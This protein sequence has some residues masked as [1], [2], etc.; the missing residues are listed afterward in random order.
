MNPEP[1]KSR[2]VSVGGRLLSGVE[3]VGLVVIAIATIIAGIQ[4]ITEMV[5]RR[6]VSLGDLLLLFIYLEVLTM[7]GIYLQSGALPIRMPLYIAMVALARHLIIDMK[8]MTETAIIAT[9]IA[10]LILA[11]AV[12][13]IRFGHVRFPYS[14]SSRDED[15]H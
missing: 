7:V 11:V 14:A 5:G 6:E 8:E 12:L 10:I 13:L 9:S 1:S 15:A 4:E 3:I 2:I